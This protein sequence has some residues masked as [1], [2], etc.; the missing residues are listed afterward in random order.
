MRPREETERRYKTSRWVGC[1]VPGTKGTGESA[2]AA[3]RLWRGPERRTRFGWTGTAPRGVRVGTVV[4]RRVGAC[5]PALGARN[6]CTYRSV[7]MVRVLRSRSDSHQV[8][9]G[10]VNR[11]GLRIASSLF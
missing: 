2:M 9:L 11:L 7:L 1:G 4:T 8:S 3:N 6:L 10:V 5:T